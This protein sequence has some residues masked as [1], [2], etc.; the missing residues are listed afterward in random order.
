MLLTEAKQLTPT[1]KDMTLPRTLRS[2]ALTLCFS[3]CFTGSLI[4]QKPFWETWGEGLTNF[5]TPPKEGHSQTPIWGH[6]GQKFEPARTQQPTSTRSKVQ[7]TH[8]NPWSSGDEGAFR[9][10]YR[11][12]D[13]EKEPRNKWGLAIQKHTGAAPTYPKFSNEE[14]ESL[15]KQLEDPDNL[16]KMSRNADQYN[17]LSRRRG[18]TDSPTDSEKTFPSKSPEELRLPKRRKAPRQTS[19]NYSGVS[20]HD[21]HKLIG[22]I[23]AESS[24]PPQKIPARKKQEIIEIFGSKLPEELTPR[25]R[26]EVLVKAYGG[27]TAYQKASANKITTWGR[28]QMDRIYREVTGNDVVEIRKDRYSLLRLNSGGK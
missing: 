20:M 21:Y 23:D 15:A 10:A 26:R 1:Q 4:A 24:T 5:F 17:A 25:Q 13:A 28:G 9:Q 19:Q 3:M 2:L 6:L 12:K 18:S 16:T 7:K 8:S 27:E 14:M 22:Q 11:K